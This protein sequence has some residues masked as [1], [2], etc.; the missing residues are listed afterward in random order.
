MLIHLSAQR[1]AQRNRPLCAHITFD[2]IKDI[3]K[4]I[5]VVLAII[6]WMETQ[7]NEFIVYFLFRGETN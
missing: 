7:A 4:A 2:C 6:F 5:G 3:V 1:S